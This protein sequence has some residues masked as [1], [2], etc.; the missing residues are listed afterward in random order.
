MWRPNQPRLR[1][2]GMNLA[3]KAADLPMRTP[4]SQSSQDSMMTH[5]L[6]ARRIAAK[7]LSRVMKNVLRNTAGAGRAVVA[8]E[9]ADENRTIVSLKFGPR[10]V[11]TTD[12]V[13]SGR[14]PKSRMNSPTTSLAQTMM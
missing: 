3:L 7:I 5:F 9:A 12:R 2:F 8:A 13:R 14:D 1:T 4:A 6:R 11:V 10:H